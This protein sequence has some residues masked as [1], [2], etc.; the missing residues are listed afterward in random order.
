LK[1][2]KFFLIGLILLFCISSCERDVKK[3]PYP[4]ELAKISKSNPSSTAGI[5]LGRM[6]F[7]EVAL[8][9]NGKQS[10]ASCH[11]PTNYFQDNTAVS[12]AHTGLVNGLR[13]TPSILYMAYKSEFFWD[14]GGENLE[15]MTAGPLLSPNEMGVNLKKAL[16]IIRKKPAIKELCF[17]AFGNDSLTS[18]RLMRSLAQYMRTLA[19]FASRYDAHEAGKYTFTASEEKG[20]VI[21]KENC[22][23]CH[24]EPLFT[25][26]DYSNIGLDTLPPDTRDLKSLFGR[27]RVTGNPQDYKAYSTPILRNVMKTAPYF[28]NGSA[29]TIEEVIEFYDRGGLPSPTTDPRVSFKLELTK[30][31]KFNLI[32]FLHTLT[33]TT[34][35][36]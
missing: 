13:S 24:N 26:N 1:T 33:D 10:C 32:T 9:A 16:A 34:V 7:N 31:D 8:S 2:S 20:Y 29:K 17:V 19:P 5:A 6:L 28:H 14:G 35:I 12:A 18:Q 22:R 23:K 21:F 36:R 4:N 15:S 25:N 11:N 3:L 27:M 30:L